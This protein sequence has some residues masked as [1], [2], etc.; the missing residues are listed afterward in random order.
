MDFHSIYIVNKIVLKGYQDI[1]VFAVGP[2]P[3]RPDSRN[4]NAFSKYKVIQLP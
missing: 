3:D 4:C 1:S 2:E